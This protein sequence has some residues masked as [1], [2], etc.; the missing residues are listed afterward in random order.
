MLWLCVLAKTA[1]FYVH[2]KRLIVNEI[3]LWMSV[4]SFAMLSSSHSVISQWCIFQ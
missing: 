4:N 2:L 1:G 3:W